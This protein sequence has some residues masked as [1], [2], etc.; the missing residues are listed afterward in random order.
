MKTIILYLITLSTFAMSTN[1]FII[2]NKDG[3]IIK[4]KKITHNV[5]YDEFLAQQKA[6]L[7]EIERAKL[8]AKQHKILGQ[9]DEIG[10]KRQ[11]L[12]NIVKNA[13]RHLGEPYV[14]GGTIPGGFDCSGY[15]QYIY[16]KEGVAIPRTAYE[17]SKVGKEV[18]RSNLRKGDLLFFLTDKSRGIPIT[19]VGMYIG[20][21]KF[22]HAASKRQ[23]I[24]ISSFEK[25]RYAKLFVK[26]KRIIK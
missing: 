18:S 5:Y 3:Q 20:N 11:N 15:M 6:L 7:E 10:N 19:H 26:A 24:I 21:G 1:M 22:I 25:S 12:A 4:D 23:G 17:Q 14:W 8:L 13:Q 2:K 16:K 9:L